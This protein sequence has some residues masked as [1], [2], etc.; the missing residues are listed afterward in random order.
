MATTMIEAVQMLEQY[1]QII[2]RNGATCVASAHA[3]N[4]GNQVA[5]Y[6]N[7]GKRVLE[8]PRAIRNAARFMVEVA[9]DH[10][11]FQD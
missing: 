7:G 11:W 10:T 5:I 2:G 3:Y 9:A 4:N 6:A 8:G 1:G